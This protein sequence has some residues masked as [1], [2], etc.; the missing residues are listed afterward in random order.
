LIYSGRETR[1]AAKW[2]C[3]L[4][5]IDQVICLEMVRYSMISGGAETFD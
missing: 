4:S 2:L 1:Q 3:E 5:Q